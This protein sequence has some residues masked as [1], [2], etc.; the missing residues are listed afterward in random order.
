MS[1]TCEES[2]SPTGA[3]SGEYQLTCAVLSEDS[4]SGYYRQGRKEEVVNCKR[5]CAVPFIPEGRLIDPWKGTTLISGSRTMLNGG[6]SARIKCPAGSYAFGRVQL[7]C[8]DGR[9]THDLP[10]CVRDFQPC[11]GPTIE[12]GERDPYNRAPG[13]SYTLTC[14]P[15]Y[16]LTVTS[17]TVVKCRSIPGR[18]T[19]LGVQAAELSPASSFSCHKVGVSPTSRTHCATPTHCAM[20]NSRYETFVLKMISPIPEIIFPV[21]I[22]S[23]S[24]GMSS[25]LLLDG[26]RNPAPRPQSVRSTLQ[27]GKQRHY[28][29]F[30]RRRIDS[31]VPGGWMGQ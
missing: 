19:D 6:D 20:L 24:P 2:Y 13:D 9:I 12:N 5:D 29:V 18:L 28:H 22:I 1:I 10:T 8:Y 11:E 14:S 7:D 23:T 15:G 3:R 27:D 25:T 26:S 4:E 17:S 16:A 30:W 31:H 21:P